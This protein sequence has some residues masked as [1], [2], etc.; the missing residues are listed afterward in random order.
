MVMHDVAVPA[1]TAAS[2]QSSKNQSSRGSLMTRFPCCWT[3][4]VSHS[5]IRPRAFPSTLARSTR[6]HAMGRG[7]DVWTPAD[8]SMPLW[9]STTH[10]G[11]EKPCGSEVSDATSGPGTCSPNSRSTPVSMLVPLRPE[12]VT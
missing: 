1:D 4:A 7:S 9:K 10:C 6:C 5:W 2:C 3:W 8:R 12:P 11:S